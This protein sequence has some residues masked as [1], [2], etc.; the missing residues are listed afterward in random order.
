M[1][2]AGGGVAPHAWWC[3]LTVHAPVY[4]A[5]REMGRLF[6]SERM[7]GNY[8]LTYA[9]GLAKSPYFCPPGQG[10]RYREDLAAVARRGV[11]VTPARAER[12]DFVLHTFKLAQVT[13]HAL[14]ER[15]TSNIPNYGRAKEIAAESVYSFLVV[16]GE[17]PPRWV[18]LGKWDSKAEIEATPVRLREEDARFTSC[19]PMNPLDLPYPP[20][21]Y[22]I[23]S[24]R[25]VSLLEQAVFSGPCWR[26]EG[27]PAEGRSGEPRRV[28]AGLGFFRMNPNAQ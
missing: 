8:A 3:T 13:Y 27:A 24:V 10:P 22:D 16:G 25:P 5:S 21:E 4:F 11:Y 9:L 26:I 19:L 12:V 6:E 28:P 1:N 17:R 23:V 15:P 7:I 20:I 2:E 18:R 14:P